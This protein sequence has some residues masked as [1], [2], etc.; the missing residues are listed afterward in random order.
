MEEG[1]GTKQIIPILLKSIINLLAMA[2]KSY[3]N[4]LKFQA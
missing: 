2:K 1:L 4:A 3:R